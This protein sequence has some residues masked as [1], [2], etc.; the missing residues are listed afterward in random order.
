MNER[1]LQ[2]ELERD[3]RL[4]AETEK[5]LYLEGI[6]DVGV[7]LGLL[8][9]IPPSTLAGR[10]EIIDGVQVRGLRA[11]AG[12]GSS[13]VRQRVEVATRLGYRG[14]HGMLDG[15]GRTLAELATAF[16]APLAGQLHQWKTYCIENLL[17][18]VTWP[19]DWGVPPDWP[20][21]LTRFAPYAA[22][23]RVTR[24]LHEHLS[25][26]RIA[27]FTQPSRS[28]TLWT[29]DRF[30]EQLRQDDSS[31]RKLRDLVTFFDDELT[32]CTRATTAKDPELAEAHALI[33][34]KWLVEVH[35]PPISHRSAED[36]RAMWAAHVG[37]RGGHPDVRAWWQRFLA[38]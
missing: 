14:I 16:D 5:V 20:D 34:G 8:G 24:W 13:G 7:F 21:V 15:D 35:A 31:A 30:R 23:N 17:A 6:T 26:L 18:Q 37:A 36:C 12:S 4:A 33:N 27:K 9:R 11:T 29:A 32:R 22:I 3:L 1:E 2:S 10:G 28:Q 38:A 19:D 25:S